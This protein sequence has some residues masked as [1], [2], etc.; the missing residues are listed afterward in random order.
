MPTFDGV[1]LLITLDSGVTNVDVQED[2]Y[3]PWKTWMLGSHDNR[4]YPEAFRSDGGAPLTDVISQGSYFFLNN[5]EGWRIKPPEEDITI[6]LTGNLAVEDTG[7]DAVVPTTGAFTAAIIGL[8]PVTQALGQQELA[9]IKFL[10][11]STRPHHT[12]QGT[13]L[14]WDPESGL[15]TNSGLSASQAVKTFAQAHMLATDGAHDII[16]ALSTGTGQTVVTETIEITKR[17][18]FLRGP[19]RDFLVKPTTDTD[20]TITINAVGVEVS[21]MIVETASAGGTPRN[22]IQVETGADFFNIEN[23]WSHEST[24]AGVHVDGEVVYGRITDCFFAHMAD[25]GIHLNGTGNG[26]RHT[27]ILRTEID[28][29][30]SDGIVMEATGTTAR[31]NI[32]EDCK[33]Y[34]CTGYGVNLKSA[35]LRNIIRNTPIYDNVAGEVLDDGT[36]NEVD[37]NLK[38]MWRDRGFDPNNPVT[39]DE[40]AKT[41]TV[42]GKV[43]TWAG[44]LIKTFTRTT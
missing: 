23:V 24:E 20:H 13:V 17:Y 43:R 8:Q 32:V 11:E 42:A 21:G 16:V 37:Q 22:A 30:G 33:I 40:S 44:D 4:R 1:N 34:D 15:D 18:V 36:D 29:A 41:V 39:F 27:R 9:N 38:D 19:G 25:H 35:S 3:E 12:G 7:L 26:I 14:Y 28:D 31:N 2:I 10:I 5:A 6:Y